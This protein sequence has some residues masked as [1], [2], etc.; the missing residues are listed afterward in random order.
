MKALEIRNNKTDEV[1]AACVIVS[2]TRC[3][4]FLDLECL[5]ESRL[6]TLEEYLKDPMFATM[7]TELFKTYFAVDDSIIVERE[8]KDGRIL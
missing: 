3:V 1:V 6:I 7:P 4:P 8:I 5:P 2:D